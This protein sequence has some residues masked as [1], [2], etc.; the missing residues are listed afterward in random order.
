M[1]GQ[2]GGVL[3]SLRSPYDAEIAK[4]AIPALG[5]LVAEPLYVLADTAIVGN[6]GT[7]ELA[8]LALASTVLLTV[9]AVMIFLAYG[10]TGPV[11][12]LI[13]SGDTTAAAH[14]SLQ[15][16]WLAGILGI[17][18]SILLW[19]GGRTFLGWL[20]GSGAE[21]VAAET[22]L[23]VSL[24]GF[25]FLLLAL[26]ANGSFHGRQNA[27]IPLALAIAGAAINIVIELILI[28]GLGYGI[29]ASA[30][31]TVIAQV[32][33]GI[34]AT[35]LVLRWS[36]AS[37]AVNRPDRATM[38]ALLGTS[39]ALIVRTMSLR[40]SFTLST[41]IAASLGVVDVAAHQVALAVWS[42]LAL[43]LDAVAIAGQSLTG[44]W[45]GVGDLTRARAA[46]RRMI[47]V[48]VAVGVVV[49]LIIVVFRQPLAGLFSDDQELVDLIAFTLAHVGAQQPLNGVVFALD[50]I[51]IGAG[52]LNYL[53]IGMVGAGVAFVG[54][55]AV[56]ITTGAG[57]GWLWAAIAA[58]MAI[59]AVPLVLR[60]RQDAWLTA[61]P[62]SV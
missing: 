2:T 4:L 46:T 22:Y 57:L 48:D 35:V 56:I 20:G 62:T 39:K 3:A 36:I 17:G 61:A 49:G 37:G 58:F 10:T 16:I 52:D 54:L 30:L 34:T 42:T 25:P 50:G 6:I 5:S 15:G 53:A 24:L 43:A 26:A 40:G 29:G 47:E 9:H 38:A 13:G 14:R 44:K 1:S 11:A 55:C 27:V 41:A 45:L 19:A 12:R 28:P 18:S 33:V 32:I 60:W 7:T 23:N 59:R 21:L 8:G 51:L 31:S